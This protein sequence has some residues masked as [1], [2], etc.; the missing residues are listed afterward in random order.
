MATIECEF[1]HKNTKNTD[2]YSN[3]KTKNTETKWRNHRLII[4]Q[5]VV[6]LTQKKNFDVNHKH[7]A[8]AP[9]KKLT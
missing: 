5:N 9:Y 7:I 6:K 8:Q 3:K 2:K 4:F 1:I